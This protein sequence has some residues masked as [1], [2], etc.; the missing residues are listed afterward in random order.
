MAS[1]RGLAPSVTAV[2]GSGSPGV[3]YPALT[4]PDLPT[5]I[6]RQRALPEAASIISKL[7][8]VGGFP[9]VGGL[10]IAFDND[11]AIVTLHVQLPA[12]FNG[13]DGPV[14][15][16]VQ[17]RIG[18][19]EPFHVVYGYLGDTTGGTKVDLGP[20]ALSGFGICF[21]EHYSLD[22]SVDPCPGMQIDS[23]LQPVRRLRRV[24]R[25]G[26]AV[27]HRERLRGRHRQR[28][29]LPIQRQRAWH[30]GVAADRR[31]VPLHQPCRDRRQ[32]RGFADLAGAAQI[33]AQISGAG[34][35][36]RLVYRIARQAG[37]SVEFYE[38][39]GQVHRLLG[40]TTAGRGTLAFTASHGNG[41]RQIVA[42]VYGDGVPRVR[43]PVTSYPRRGS[44]DLVGPAICACIADERW[45]RSPSPACPAPANTESTSCSATDP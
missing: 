1:T 29:P 13:G 19:T 4:V 22:T 41:R 16:A 7:G 39:S 40:T 24:E 25:R 37:Q 15:A 33:S 20:V 2:R 34:T 31:H 18:P 23:D 21:R 44:H 27:D 12:P 14:T 45:Q 26:P 42:E 43:M 3:D 38:I 30:R 8:A 11:T 5:E 6:P 32:R 17:A 36:R 35:H 28:F 9:S 10:E